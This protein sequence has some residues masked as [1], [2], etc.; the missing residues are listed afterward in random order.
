MI[1]G[2]DVGDAAL[3]RLVAG[4]LDDAHPADAVSRSAKALVKPAGMCCAMT[5]GGTSAGI[6][7][8][9]V[10]IAWVP[11]VDAPMAMSPR[12][13]LALRGGRLTDGG[14]VRRHLP[15]PDRA[16]GAQRPDPLGDAV[17]DL[18]DGVRAARLAD[19]VDGADAQRLDAG[20]RALLRQRADDDGRNRMV[21]HQLA[22][23]AE[24]VHARH[25]DVE[26]DDVGLE[27]QDHVP[28][29]VRIGG[30]A[31]HLDVVVLAQG[32]AE[33]LADDRRVVDEEDAGAGPGST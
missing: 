3:E 16:A 32:V 26:R 14:A 33:Q 31:D 10:S 4:R 15:E 27:L 24:A 13:R 29:D 11:P 17:G 9:T 25:L 20:G 12:R 19:D 8:S 2:R 18:A 23:E 1:A 5:I 21:L 28:R 30:A 22:Q 7:V 6:R